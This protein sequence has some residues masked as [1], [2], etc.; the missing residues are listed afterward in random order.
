MTSK[1]NS[2][3][4]YNF[5]EQKIAPI[6]IKIGE[7]KH[8]AAIKDSFM[9]IISF[10][11]IGSVFLLITN[12]TMFTAFNDFIAPYASALNVGYTLTFG[13]A[14]IYFTYAF[15]YNL[16]NNYGLSGKTCG[17][18]SEMV[19]LFAANPHIAQ[20]G[21]STDYLGVGGFLA[22][23]VFTIYTVELY[24]FCIV[25][26][27]YLKAPE[28]VP[29]AVSN[30]FNTLIPQTIVLLPVFFVVN[31]L[32]FDITGLVYSIF[33][34]FAD[35]VD[36]FWS[37]YFMT[38]FVDNGLF[39][40]GVHPWTVVGALYLPVITAN[41]V[42]NAELLAAGEPMKY[43]QTAAFYNGAKWGGTGGLFALT[44][45]CL[46]SKSKRFKTLGKISF[47]PTLCGIGETILFGLPVAFNPL[48]FIPFVILQPLVSYG[49]FY[50][51]TAL[52]WVTKGFIPLS[53]FL[54]GPLFLYLGTLDWRAP[55]FGIISALVLP[56]LVYYPF[57]KVQEKIELTN[58]LKKEVET[59]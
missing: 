57:F 1:F 5:I 53:G 36:S 14:A 58:E 19:F 41:T 10:I 11:M 20:N 51:F 32:G 24:R 30:F 12:L 21:F 45:L 35:G 29:Q 6:A 4:F 50:I 17:L 25:K 2:N 34:G 13:F 7:E 26:K 46:F 8:V 55:L 48:F 44:I 54:P 31:C 49:S 59:A 40:F 42:A 9:E 15:G 28:G 18:L 27:I 47:I 22:S 38:V 37:L 16:G 56:M 39:F 23:I 3:V 43:I 52:G 33:Q